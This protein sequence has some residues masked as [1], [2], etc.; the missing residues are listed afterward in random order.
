MGVLNVTPDSFSDGGQHFA[1]E[2]AVHAAQAMIAAGADIIDIGGESTRP[3]AEIVPAGEE[4]RRT[5]PVIEAL[6][7]TSNA[8]LS[9]DTSKAAVAAEALAAGAD[10]VNDVSGFTFEPEIARVTAD[11]DAGAVLMHTPGRSDVM[12]DLATYG[13]VVDDVARALERS[14]ATARAAGLSDERIAIDPGFGFGKTPEQNYLLLRGLPR[15]IALGFPVLV[16]MSR[17]R[18]IRAAVGPQPHALEHGT[19]AA[20]TLAAVAGAHVVRV[21]DVPAAVAAASVFASWSRARA[22]ES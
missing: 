12:D 5:V 9:I 19:T 6:R 11:A 17:K 20:D 8:V 2:A 4:I 10:I 7:A 15:I 16:G 21:H 18:M 3:G 22:P 13:D 14:V 1:L